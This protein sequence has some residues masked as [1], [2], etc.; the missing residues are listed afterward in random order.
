MRIL[1]SYEA[2]EMLRISMPTLYRYVQQGLIPC[3]RIGRRTLFRY[4]ELEAVVTNR[5]KEDKHV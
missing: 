1:T 4:E 5:L 3:F 2:A